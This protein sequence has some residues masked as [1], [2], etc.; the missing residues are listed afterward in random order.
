MAYLG[1]PSVVYNYLRKSEVASPE[2]VCCL[3]QLKLSVCL[4]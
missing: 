2:L 4:I 3:F 1:V